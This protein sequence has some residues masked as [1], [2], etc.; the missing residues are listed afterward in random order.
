MSVARMD[1]DAYFF[2]LQSIDF[3]LSFI[4]DQQIIQKSQISRSD[5]Y[6]LGKRHWVF[7]PPG[8]ESEPLSSASS[9]PIVRHVK[10]K[11]HA[12]PF[13][14]K[15]DPYLAARKLASKARNALKAFW[16]ILS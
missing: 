1:R 6:R 8:K 9:V 16:S 4:F 7:M 10:I 14:P 5:E 12:R 13:H 3:S 11:Q 2:I 15:W